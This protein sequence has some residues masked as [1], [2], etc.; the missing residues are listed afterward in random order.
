MPKKPIKQYTKNE[1]IYK[2]IVD[3][4]NKIKNIRN[5][6]DEDYTTIGYRAKNYELVSNLGYYKSNPPKNQQEEDEFETNKI[7]EKYYQELASRYKAYLNKFDSFYKLYQNAKNLQGQSIERERAAEAAKKINEMAKSGNNIDISV[8]SEKEIAEL[9]DAR[10]EYFK[11][12]RELY[13]LQTN[14]K[15]YE[16]KEVLENLVKDGLEKFH[17]QQA[18]ERKEEE[19]Y[20]KPYEEAAKAEEEYIKIKQKWRKAELDKQKEIEKQQAEEKKK[21]EEAKAKEEAEKQEAIKEKQQEELYL[22]N[23]KDRID[24]G[25]LSTYNNDFINKIGK[26]L[27][28]DEKLNSKET[29]EVYGFG[30]E[31]KL[32]LKEAYE[33]CK[34]STLAELESQSEFNR[35]ANRLS[36]ITEL[37]D[38][39]KNSFDNF[40]ELFVDSKEAPKKEQT[41]P[42]KKVIKNEYKSLTNRMGDFGEA[43]RYV[44]DCYNNITKENGY[45]RS[46][47]GGMISYAN[48]FA[49]MHHSTKEPGFFSKLFNTNYNKSYIAQKET[50]DKIKETLGKLPISTDFIDKITGENTCKNPI[51]KEELVDIYNNAYKPEDPFNTSEQNMALAE[52]KAMTAIVYDAY[53]NKNPVESIDSYLKKD[54]EH[55]D[56]YNSDEKEY[57][58]RFEDLDNTINERMNEKLDNNRVRMEIEEC[59]NEAQ[60]LDE[61]EVVQDNEKQMV[62]EPEIQNS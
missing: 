8:P 19:E 5:R 54:A 39:F 27:N 52:A 18:I 21:A 56:K 57:G 20:F 29:Y 17:E 41:D 40:K 24:D 51:E 9:H 59:A 10:L 6:L 60:V 15:D 16:K 49:Q 28:I 1:L 53:F 11:A 38:G 26:N 23:C 14:I 36:T 30:K 62:N 42:N 58:N 33:A 48:Q 34:Q 32:T 4:Y 35:T 3:N 7:E 43:K 25:Y 46:S 12:G 2:D 22:K 50:L 13:T 37:G 45:A 47:F 31:K 55:I 61:K 44:E